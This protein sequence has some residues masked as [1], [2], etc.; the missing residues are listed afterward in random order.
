MARKAN[1]PSRKTIN[2]AIPDKHPKG[3]AR[4]TDRLD[5]IPTNKWTTAELAELYLPEPPWKLPAHSSS[6]DNWIRQM[7]LEHVRIAQEI[8]LEAGREQHSQF[9]ARYYEAT[10]YHI[11]EIIPLDH[12]LILITNSRWPGEARKLARKYLQAG[13]WGVESQLK[14]ALAW[15]WDSNMPPAILICYSP[16]EIDELFKRLSKGFDCR[17]FVYWARKL[18]QTRLRLRAKVKR[19]N[20][21]PKKVKKSSCARKRVIDP[22]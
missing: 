11:W 18:A 9:A 15:L 4:K 20:L 7:R 17:E 3:K 14:S 5:R 2:S 6:T 22:P 16:A 12:A 19:Q 13:I 21:Q 1:Q 8:E 10:A